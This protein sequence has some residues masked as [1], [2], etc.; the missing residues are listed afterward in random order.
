MREFYCVLR[1]RTPI[2]NLACTL[3]FLLL[4][5]FVLNALIYESVYER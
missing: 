1:S 3:D 5:F 4:P 2:G